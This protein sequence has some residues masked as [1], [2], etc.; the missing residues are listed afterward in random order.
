MANAK[1]EE[2]EPH[3]RHIGSAMLV[4]NTDASWSVG[5][6]L[7]T[8]VKVT[9][10]DITAID[11]S[12]FGFSAVAVE[13]NGTGGYRLFVRSD[14]DEDVIIE[15]AVDAAGRV[16][17]ASVA[18]LTQ[19]Q[20]FATEEQYKVDLND[21]GG[22]GIG[23]VLLQGG[24]TNLY[25]NELGHYL[26]GDGSAAP[27]TLLLGGQPLD[28]Q[29]L[30]A[31]WEI[32]EL[33]ARADGWDVYAQAPSG[34]IFD[35]R[36]NASGEY[37]GGDLLV[38]AALDA[39][40]Q[41][42]G[43]DIDG[44]ND[45]PAPAGWT[46]VI[47]NAL[48]RNAI[49]SALAAPAARAASAFALAAPLDAAGTIT[50]AELVGVLKA[51]IQA[52]KAN[53]DAPITAQE[54]ADLQALAARGKAAFAGNGPAAEYLSYSLAKLV[55]GSDANRFFTGGST[56][57]SEL[58]ALGANSP[59]SVLEKLVDKWLLGGDMPS[60]STA[61]DSATGAAKSVVAVYAKSTGTLFVDGVNVSDVY[62]GSAGDCYLIAAIGG[63]AISQPAAL[64]ALFVE[65]AAIDGV[66]SW[67]V[68]LFD[69]NGAAHWVTVNDML[70]VPAAGDT[71]VAY[72]GSASKD[73]NGEIWV[74]LLEK[75][76][77]QA[78][79]LGFLPR[80]ESTGQNSFAAVEGGQGDPLGAL[81]AGKVIAF[82]D[83][84][85]NFGNNGYLVARGVDRNDVAA[86]SQLEAELKT[87]INAGKTVW[88][89]VNNTLKDTFGN[90]LLV[91]SHAHFILDA[92]PA[93][94]NNSDVLVYNPWGISPLPNP[95]GPVP[96]GSAF[97][98]PANFTLAELVGIVGL[99]FMVLDTPAG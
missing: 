62:Q 69:A 38:G 20:L 34:V 77:A 50:H 79:A 31:G 92:N 96:G 81:I 51:V 22:F 58:G 30:P 18:V 56:Q 97:V 27:K 3:A 68:R 48:I 85:A 52:H 99:D 16:D 33:L 17:P 66:R 15:V 28:D 93:D 59:V 80:A 54:V 67:G 65:N 26:L 44:D 4:I 39:V 55:E 73:L 49:D 29:L 45:L 72:A 63:L 10:A 86:K 64:Q 95:P 78:N 36:F 23:L 42:A 89:G 94:P 25:M 9:F 84:G 32:V 83:P 61:G 14:L 35:A 74:T 13:R 70:P 88:L 91:G 71:K 90:Q 1:V 60:P 7:A 53:N 19:A 40:E 76:Y 98:S 21:S 57:R 2:L 37:I 5:A 75:A 41:T 82:S 8:A 87:Y 47:S 46:S 24:V 12:T 11:D 6:T 43:V